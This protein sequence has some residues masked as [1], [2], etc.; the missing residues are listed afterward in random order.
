MADQR[1]ELAF[2]DIQ[3]DI[4]QCVEAA[5]LGVEDHFNL[6]DLYVLVVDFV[7]DHVPTSS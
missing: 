3:I 7:H 2:F 1:N 5:L 6:I 4:A